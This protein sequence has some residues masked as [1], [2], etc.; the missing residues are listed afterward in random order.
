MSCKKYTFDDFYREA[1][2]RGFELISGEEDYQNASSLMKYI[3]PKH[4]DKGIQQTTLGRLLEGK[5]CY[6]CGVEKTA[7]K[8]R[9]PIEQETIDEIKELC[10]E[11]DFEFVKIAREQMGGVNKICVYFVCNKHKDKGVQIVP[12]NNFR[13]NKKCQYCV[14]KNL[15]KKDIE[16]LVND[17]MPQIKIL[18]DY[19]I[20]NDDIEYCCTKHN[21]YGHTTP[22][23]LIKGRGCYYCGLEK[24][25]K[26]LSL[27][28]EEVDIKIKSVNPNF[29]RIGE[30]TYS[31]S[32]MKMRCNKCGYTWYKSLVNLRFCPNCEKEKMYK[33]EHI[34][35]D[36][37]QEEGIDFE[38]QKRYDDCRNIRALPFDFYLPKYN[39]CIEY[40]GVQ[41]YRPVDYFG[42]EDSYKQQVKNDAIKRE[43]CNKNGIGLITVPYKYDTKEKVSNY[44]FSQL[45]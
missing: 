10:C 11:R 42:G 17:K 9:K 38:T 26:E 30:Y 20:L 25:S 27:S 19:T 28:I 14:H 8:R 24:L 33:G 3:C 23:N 6:Y 5:E 15:S 12:I 2:K 34:I 29:E 1:K 44:I 13:R 4:Q 41:H 45:N 21:Y 35:F 39:T 31:T 37:L 36:I 32:P 22:A 16:K 40:N 18:T 43:Y 7:S